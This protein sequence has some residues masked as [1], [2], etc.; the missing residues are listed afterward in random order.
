[1]ILKWDSYGVANIIVLMQL[2]IGIIRDSAFQFYY[3]ENLD[4]L[5]RAGARL[6]EFSALTGNLPNSLDSEWQIDIKKSI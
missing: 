3:P 5:K 2:N 1:M 4:A 6:I